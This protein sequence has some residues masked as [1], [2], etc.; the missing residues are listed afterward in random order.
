MSSCE[1]GHYVN[2]CYYYYN[3]KNNKKTQHKDKANLYIKVL[4]QHEM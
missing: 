4:K 1:K 2:V 3:K